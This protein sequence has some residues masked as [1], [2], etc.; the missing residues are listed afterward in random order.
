[1]FSPI[2]PPLR[3]HTHTHASLARIADALLYPSRTRCSYGQASSD[4]VHVYCMQYRVPTVWISHAVI[5]SIDQPCS[6][7][8]LERLVAALGSPTVRLCRRWSGVLVTFSMNSSTETAHAE[9]WGVATDK[10]I[11]PIER[12]GEL[13]SWQS[14]T[15][16]QC[17]HGTAKGTHPSTLGRATTLFL[18]RPLACE[19]TYVGRSCS[20]P[21]TDLVP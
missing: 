15:C 7:L 10:H 3:V 1:M 19:V 17:H 16:E 5:I 20:H 8:P 14:S 4:P 21:S 13:V 11:S 9:P 2:S 18:A 12:A 6:V